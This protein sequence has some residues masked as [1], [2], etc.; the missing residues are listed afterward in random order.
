M[1][2]TIGLYLQAKYYKWQIL[3][4]KGSYLLKGIFG[5]TTCPNKIW[6]KGNMIQK[7]SRG[8]TEEIKAGQRATCLCKMRV[9]PKLVRANESHKRPPSYVMWL[10]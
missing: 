1:D 9:F 6:A 3:F 5:H 7:T 4:K 8:Q 10:R 2:Y